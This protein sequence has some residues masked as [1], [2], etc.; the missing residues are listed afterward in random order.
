ME[1]PPNHL[2]LREVNCFRL[3]V[4][5][6]CIEWFLNVCKHPRA[7]LLSFW[8]EVAHGRSITNEHRFWFVD[9]EDSYRILCLSSAICHCIYHW[10][11]EVLCHTIKRL[12]CCT[13]AEF[14]GRD[15][16]CYVHISWH[17]HSDGFGILVDDTVIDFIDNERTDFC[18]ISL[19]HKLPVEVQVTICYVDVLN[20][21]HIYRLSLVHICRSTFRDSKLSDG[22]SPCIVCLRQ[23][24]RYGTWGEVYLSLIIV[25]C[26]CLNRTISRKHEF[27][28]V[29]VCAGSKARHKENG[30]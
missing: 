10:W 9:S 1:M 28:D 13:L 30:E 15:E 14:Y 6:R 25:E 23:I 18:L 8:I 27:A 2:A 12:A 7:C 4:S 11:G 22:H 20:T 24:N 29:I 21:L 16:S 3:Y 17:I 19:C 26:Q 5:K